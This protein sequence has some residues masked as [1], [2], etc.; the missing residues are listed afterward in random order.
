MSDSAIADRRILIV[1]DE[2]L[3]A[4][5]LEDMLDEL[6]CRVVATV[7]NA[8]DAVAAIEAH[9]IDAAILDVNLEGGRS[10]AV[11]D[12]LAGHGIPF[13]FSTGYGEHT[14]EAQYPNR[15][16]LKKPFSMGDLARAL[17][18]VLQAGS[19]E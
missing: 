3:I 15:P 14:V 19:P 4:M 18:R 12:A 11:A 16:I 17:S 6:G 13:L 10:F 2:I 7:A 1:E 5:M 8:A 9:P